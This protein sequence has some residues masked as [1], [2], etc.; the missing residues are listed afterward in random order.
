VATNGS[1]V[2]ESPKALGS[3][4]E[5]TRTIDPTNGLSARKSDCSV[6]MVF[7]ADDSV[8]PP[9]SSAP[10]FVCVS[11][12]RANTS[13]GRWAE[14]LGSEDGATSGDAV[15]STNDVVC[16]SRGFIEVIDRSST[17]CADGVVTRSVGSRFSDLLVSMG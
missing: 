2:V 14:K 15:S 13:D 1:S 5:A 6:W 10:T 11:A 17:S 7:P 8:S 3:G 4:S 12:V 9:R 16:C